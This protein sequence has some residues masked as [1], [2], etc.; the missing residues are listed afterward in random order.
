MVVEAPEG[1]TSTQRWPSPYAESLRFSKPSFSVK[2]STAWSWS[3]TVTITVPTWVM[4]VAA[5]VSGMRL[6]LWL[7]A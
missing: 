4:R 2:N 3:L 1:A 6:L 5:P 7:W